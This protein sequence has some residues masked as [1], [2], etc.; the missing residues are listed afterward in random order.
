MIEMPEAHTIA[1]QMKTELTGRVISG[2]SQGILT[3]KFLWLNRPVE[4]FEV[5]LPGAVVTTASSY[6]RS[7]YLHLD[8]RMLWWGDAGGRLLFHP[9]G[10]DLFPKNITWS[11]TLQMEVH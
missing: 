5:V 9:D 10:G 8:D 11:G 6:G 2:F 3:H 7:I 4:E 1:S